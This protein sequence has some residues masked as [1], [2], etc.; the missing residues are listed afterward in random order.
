MTGQ[1][2]IDEETGANLD[3]FAALVFAF[4]HQGDGVRSQGAESLQDVRFSFRQQP[5]GGYQCEETPGPANDHRSS[6]VYCL[7]SLL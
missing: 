2:V 5:F 7:Q 1:E 3:Q 6:I 4:G